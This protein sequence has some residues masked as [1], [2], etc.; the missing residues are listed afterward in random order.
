M[1]AGAAAAQMVTEKM[2]DEQR[3][4]DEPRRARAV[5]PGRTRGVRARAAAALRAAAERLEPA[6]SGRGDAA[7]T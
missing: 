5:Q 1:I 7:T 2:E 6:C 3:F 4:G